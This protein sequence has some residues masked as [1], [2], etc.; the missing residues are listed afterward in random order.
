MLNVY[1]YTRGVA[2]TNIIRKLS[3][4]MQDMKIESRSMSVADLL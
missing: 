2:Y 3:N 1:A 4:V